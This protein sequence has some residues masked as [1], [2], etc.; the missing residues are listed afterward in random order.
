MGSGAGILAAGLGDLEIS[1]S[2]VRANGKFVAVTGADGF[3]GSHVV[4][5]LLGKGYMVRGTVQDLDPA[6]V[7]F[8]K[9]LPQADENLS[10]FKGELLDKGCFDDVFRGCDCVFHLASPTLKHQSEMK[11]PEI[12]MIDQ[13]V[14]GMRNVLQSCKIA[15]VK[16]VVIT[17]SIGAASPKPD[18]PRM[19]NESHWADHELQMKKGAYHAAAKTLAERAAVEFLAKMPTESA[20]RL[21]RICPAFTVGPMLQPSVNSSMERFAAM[22]SGIHH[23][24]IRND[25][26]SM[27]DVRDTAAHHVAAYEKG[28]EGRFFSTTEAWYWTL[29]YK[30]L[31]LYC[32]H[33]EDWPKPL[34]R[35]TKL[36][37]VREYSKTRMNVLGVKQRSMLKLL[38]DGVKELEL[39][40]LFTGS[41]MYLSIGGYYD[42][43]SGSGEFLFI[44]NTIQVDSNGSQTVISRISYVI[45]DM[46]KPTV[47]E[48]P[49][50]ALS[51]SHKGDFK[52][53]LNESGKRNLLLNFQLKYEGSQIAVDGLID[54]VKVSGHC[55]ITSVNPSVYN[56][57]YTTENGSDTVKLAFS[58]GDSSITFSD[59]FKVP[60]FDYDP[61]KRRFSYTAP[62]ANG[63]DFVHR[64][65]LNVDAG[66]GLVIGFVQ[67]DPKDAKNTGSK[68]YYNLK[69]VTRTPAGPT[70][71]AAELGQF[72]GYYPLSDNG[73]TFVSIVETDDV[74]EEKS[75]TSVGVSVGVCT[76]GINSTQYSSFTFQNN[77]LTFPL[78][79]APTLTFDMSSR[80]VSVF[81]SD[82][83]TLTGVNSFSAAPL[84]AFGY[85]TLTTSPNVKNQGILSISPG[86]RKLTYTLNGVRI[87]DA[88]DY[89][90]DSVQQAVKYNDTY[91]LNFC[92][93]PTRGV[94]CGVTVKGGGINNVFFA[95]S[96]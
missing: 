11:S 63:V 37:P 24:R 81:L 62:N 75:Y 10:L 70:T 23:Q 53:R 83:S 40:K 57:T 95:Y 91:I 87:F 44:D 55:Y 8:L 86:D 41:T 22:C 66:C 54:G 14:N 92:Y 26:I 94:T 74:N 51:S 25:S 65:Y 13:G 27:I 50:G 76:D 29:I 45:G 2:G 9:L 60:Q 18:R 52:L 35:G 49:Y 85:Q 6:K 84:L 72:S 42:L 39:K 15:G 59:G 12:D 71:G 19:I 30:A 80:S 7:D 96:K 36:L 67:F 16:A 1:V 20:F 34:A 17:S 88:T 4:K 46:T 79:E 69:K 43:S 68:K 28:V 56:G 78:P 21:V 90:Y 32:P 93:N 3:I 38:G 89:H 47:Y 5:I 64:L 73:S 48:L 33:I 77:K 61:I 31:E 82:G 58:N